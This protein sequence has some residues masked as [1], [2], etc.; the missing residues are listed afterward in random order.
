[1]PCCDS[2]VASGS[3]S[4]SSRRG[5][6]SGFLHLPPL[7]WPTMREVLAGRLSRGRADEARTCKTERDLNARNP[8]CGGGCGK[9]E[10]SRGSREVQGILS[11]LSLWLFQASC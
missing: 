10:G 5:E 3:G 2:K 11:R 1:M 9:Q 8:S 7:V 6:L 4:E